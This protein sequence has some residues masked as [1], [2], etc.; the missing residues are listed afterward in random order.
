MNWSDNLI[1]GIEAPTLLV[2]IVGILAA[3][4][5]FIVLYDSFRRN[6]RLGRKPARSGSNSKDATSF[7]GR[8]RLLSQVLASE[9]AKRRRRREIQARDEAK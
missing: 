1:G 5:I 2:W 4:F 3:I 7:S 8:L 6:R 9:S